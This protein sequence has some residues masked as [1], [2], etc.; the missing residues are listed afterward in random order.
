[1]NTAPYDQS[2]QDAIFT[3][4]VHIFQVMVL[5]FIYIT[6]TIL[7][8]LCPSAH[9]ASY[10]EK[11]TNL[12][13]SVSE[14]TAA[15][16]LQTGDSCLANGE[17]EKAAV[18]YM[19]ICNKLK[20]S[21]KENEKEYCASAYLKLGNLYYQK[22]D[23]IHAMESYLQGLRI[24]DSS[25][26]KHNIAEFYKNIGN[27][28]CMFLDFKKGI[29]FYKTG[30]KYCSDYP[31]RDTE[32]KLLINLTGLCIYLEK[33]EEARKYYNASLHLT[34]SIN[35]IDRF[36]DLFNLGMLQVAEGKFLQATE[37]FKNLVT[38]ATQKS[39]GPKYI[40]SAY[41]EL[42]KTYLKSDDINSALL[43]LDLCEKT[44]TRNNIQHLFLDALRD[45]SNL[46]KR[47]GKTEEAQ[48]LKAKYLMWSDSLYNLRQFDAVK[49]SQF[50]YEMD[51]VNREINTLNEHKKQQEQTIT[52]LVITLTAVCLAAFLI[53]GVVIIIYRQKKKLN[54]SYTDLYNINRNFI[55]TQECMKQ[56]HA[57]DREQIIRLT[58][59]IENLKNKTYVTNNTATIETDKHESR[60]YQSSNLNETQQN[61][62]A[63]A[64]TTIMENTEEFCSETFSLDR[65]AT[66]VG[67][68]S[69]Y[70]SQVIN[71]T[72]HKNFNN[73][74]N[75]YRIHLACKRLAD[76]SYDN[77]TIKAIGES[78]GYKSHT[79][80]V[81]IFRKITGL[82]PSMYQKMAK[83][84]GRKSA[85]TI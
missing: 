34:D 80:F 1:M 21:T 48:N 24:C 14:K 72:Y 49:N 13:N 44:A 40:C 15:Y 5:K 47:I 36:M 71:E 41:Q 73:Y 78:I 3:T 35:P 19:I 30:Y 33:L 56:R 77:Y 32:R 10:T 45:K 69:K 55:N 81:N 39:I 74:V 75:E 65:L 79:S 7:Y 60:K 66:L 8:F 28:H 11:Y 50:Q 12:I 27:V 63:D 51:K 17:Q 6:I 22:A 16:I 4:K 70:V 85:E 23:P 58:K 82:T 52:Y 9:S 53:T 29:E 67:S 57:E 54:K 59:E 62:L 64:I 43:Y 46:L 42:Y 76:T 37:L 84:E 20:D 18:L 83:E 61:A 68:N 26:N 38:Y 31:N 25:T 2:I